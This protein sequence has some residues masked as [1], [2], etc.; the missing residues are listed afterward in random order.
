MGMV[1]V[2]SSI[3]ALPL[4]RKPTTILNFRLFMQIFSLTNRISFSHFEKKI[5]AT[6]TTKTSQHPSSFSRGAMPK[7]QAHCFSCLE[8]IA[9][10]QEN[11]YL[12]PHIRIFCEQCSP[13]Y[14]FCTDILLGG[15]TLRPELC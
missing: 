12:Q 9:Y 7:I 11:V 2:M 15:K 3:D 5:T 13:Y 1:P 8:D 14:Q 4:E 10:L 6:H